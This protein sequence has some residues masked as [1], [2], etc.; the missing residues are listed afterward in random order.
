[1]KQTSR[2]G[3]ATEAAT[4]MARRSPI[5]AATAEAGMSPRICPIPSRDSTKAA[6]LG[7]APS[8]RA[9]SA[10]TGMIAPWPIS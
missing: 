1:M 8:A 7:A 4:I 3:T 9:V 5:R 6:V 10:I 2:A